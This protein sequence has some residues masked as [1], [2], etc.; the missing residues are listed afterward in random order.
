MKNYKK[1]FSLRLK[2]WCCCGSV[3]T[4]WIMGD[5]FEND[6]VCCEKEGTLCWKDVW[7]PQEAPGGLLPA[8]RVQKHPQPLR[9]QL[10]SRKQCW[11][12][13]LRLTEDIT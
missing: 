11:A 12:Q 5:A 1:Y 13:N 10:L 9:H 4:Q 6:A 2:S 3:F 8:V 7:A